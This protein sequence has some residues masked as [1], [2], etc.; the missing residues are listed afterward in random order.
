MTGPGP[1]PSADLPVRAVP[2]ARESVLLINPHSGGGKAER[3]GLV[4]E[5]RAHAVEP[6]VLAPGDDLVELAEAAVARG[7]DAVGMAGG[8]GSLGLVAGVLA[9]H[10]VAMVVVP[11]GTRNHLAMD[12]GLD[13]RDVVAAL[14]AFGSAR[15]QLIDLG[16]VNGRVFVNN[17][18]LGLY[19]EII[20]SP[21]YR[22]AKLETT[23]AALPRLLGPESRPLDLSYTD[24][25]GERH[26]TA[27]VVQVSNDAYSQL[28]GSI[29]SRPRLDSGLLGVITVELPDEPAVTAFRHAVS[30]AGSRSL[31]GYRAWETPVFAVDSSGPIDAGI[32]GEAVRLTPPLS[33]T[34]RPRALRIRLPQGTGPSPAARELRARSRLRGLSSSTVPDPH[35]GRRAEHHSA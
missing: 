5:S 17:V 32:D 27:H 11:S 4:A 35:A 26:T 18:S 21:E 3:F 14:G 10:G 28:P 12:L 33:F 7:A 22:D 1:S 31:P 19:A 23:L 24:P 9:R 34:I 13:R 16:E 8:D 2:P 30:A 15:E 20:R 25:D 29:T 6:V